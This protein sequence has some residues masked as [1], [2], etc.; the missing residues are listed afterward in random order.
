MYRLHCKYHSHLIRVAAAVSPHRTAARHITLASEWIEPSTAASTNPDK[1]RIHTS[2]NVFVFLHGLLGNR[3][4]I[5]TLAKTLCQ[6]TGRRGLLVD[7]T[8]HGQSAQQPARSPNTTLADVAHDVYETLQPQAAEW[9][10]W[11]MVGHSL[12]GR[13][14]MLYALQQPTLLPQNIWLLDTVPGALDASVRHVLMVASQ[15]ADGTLA[16]PTTRSALVEML[17]QEQGLTTSVAQWLASSFNLKQKSFSFD[18]KVAHDL[19]ADFDQ[20][21][22]MEWIKAEPVP[23]DLV[24]G[25]ANT[26]WQAAA[27]HWQELK[28]WHGQADREFRLHT[29]PTAGHWLHMDDL[30]GLVDIMVSVQRDLDERTAAATVLGSSNSTTGI[31]GT[32]SFSTSTTTA[33][34]D[35]RGNRSFTTF[36]QLSGTRNFSSRSESVLDREPMRK[37]PLT[38]KRKVPSTIRRPPYARTGIVPPLENPEGVYLHESGSIEQMRA[39]AQLARQTLDLACQVAKPGVTTDEVDAIV[40]EAIIAAGA[41]PSPLNYAGFPKSLCASVNEVICHGIPDTRP[42]RKGDVVSFDVSCFLNGVHG[43]NCGTIIVGDNEV[44]LSSMS[45]EEQAYWN[46]ARH[47]VKST[48]QALEAAIATVKPGSCLTEV[49]RAIED[50]A[51]REGL[52]SVRKYRGHGIAHEFHC[53]PFIKHYRNSD[54]LTLKEGMIFTIEPM[55]VTGDQECVEWDDEWTVVTLDKSLAAQFEHTVLVTPD[56]VEILT[57]NPLNS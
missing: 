5:M 27:G 41:Y 39:A 50:V 15:L 42:L 57:V 12:G 28:D 52:Q 53:P 2:P 1:D 29:L 18:L 47:L 4:N 40:H 22:F 48:R 44:D 56:G 6:R 8:G 9:P 43:D 23:V 35:I 45:P 14:S 13:V 38:P 36:T 16:T 54:R 7:L 55:L 17:I 3:R 34:F 26:A 10:Q 30:Q 25:G 19:V 32:R 11:T 31:T 49:G 37:Y 33:T 20:A 21:T 46:Q 24:R 51:N